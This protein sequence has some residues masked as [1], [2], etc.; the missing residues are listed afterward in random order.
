M[1]ARLSPGEYVVNAAATSRHFDLI[2]AINTD[3]CPATRK[4]VFSP[5]PR[6]RWA[7]KAPMT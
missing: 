6:P 1:L 3:A 2:H 7:R 5:A 4:A